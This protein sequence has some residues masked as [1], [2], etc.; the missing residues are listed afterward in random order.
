[1]VGLVRGVLS[2]NFAVVG[3]IAALR[4]PM[5]RLNIVKMQMCRVYQYLESYAFGSVVAVIITS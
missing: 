5:A 4:S 1:M 3:R 2:K